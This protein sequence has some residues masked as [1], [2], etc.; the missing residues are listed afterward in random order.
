MA[1]TI[2]LVRIGKKNRPF[3]RIV[4]VSKEKDGRGDVLEILGHY[5]PLP[6]NITVDVKEE[7]LQ[8]W[9]GV[10][11]KPS[12]TVKSILKKKGILI[13]PNVDK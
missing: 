5:D 6:E 9:F 7:R 12:P 8:Y 4:A 13:P 11:A 1:A 10:G 3:F 2:R